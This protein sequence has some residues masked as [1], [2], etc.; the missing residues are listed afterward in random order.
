MCHDTRDWKF[1]Y[2]IPRARPLHSILKGNRAP[3]RG[4]AG[5]KPCPGPATLLGTPLGPSLESLPCP[6][7][8]PPK[9]WDRKPLRGAPCGTLR[10]GHAD[11]ALPRLFPVPPVLE[12]DHPKNW[13][14][15]GEQYTQPKTRARRWGIGGT[16]SANPF[17][18]SKMSGARRRKSGKDVRGW[19]RYAAQSRTN[20]L[21]F[22]DNVLVHPRM[23]H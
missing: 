14:T 18:D 20:L 23:H 7:P 8:P 17:P 19:P 16:R 1:C 4:Q 21:L 6:P 9:I 15:T 5:K 3:R 22:A 10:H 2:G 11:D 13:S 12:L